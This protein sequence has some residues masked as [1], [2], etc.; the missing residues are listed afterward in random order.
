M[1]MRKSLAVACVPG[2]LL[3]VG[4]STPSLAAS[5]TSASAGGVHAPV[6]A[7]VGDVSCQ[8]GPPVEGEAQKDVCDKT[9]AGYTTRWQAQTA[10]AA[11]IEAMKPDLVAILGDE[12]YEVGRYEDFMASFDHTYGA[13]KWLHRPAPGNHEFYSEHG[14]SGVHGYGY[15][16]YY[17]GYQVDPNTGNPVTTS[18]SAGDGGAPVVQPIPLQDGQAGNVGSNGNGWYSYNLGSWHIISLNAECDVQPGGCDSNGEWLASQTKWLAQDLAHNRAPCTLAYWHQPTFSS[19]DAA[20]PGTKFTSPE[21]TAADTW[22]KLLYRY[23]ADVV[24]NGH[25]HLYARYAPMDPSGNADPAKGIREFIVGTGGESLDQPVQN[26][27]SQ[28]IE[29]ATGNYYGVMKLTLKHDGYDWDYESAM[30]SPDAPSSE[31]ATFT[32]TGSASCHSLVANN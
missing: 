6:L 22:W 30:K 23:G 4:A 2:A 1:L 31:P 7:A 28:N 20:V 9:G 32:D 29:A 5:T 15:F 8:P 26:A 19:G 17:N 3:M 25:D 24:L 21:G 16:D 18:V 10:T 13:F 27:N 14:E 12:Q 11:Q